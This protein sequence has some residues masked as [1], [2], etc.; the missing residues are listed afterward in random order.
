MH[1]KNLNG[2]EICGDFPFIINSARKICRVRDSRFVRSSVV[3]FNAALSTSNS[4]SLFL[5]STD[6]GVNGVVVVEPGVNAAGVLLDDEDP[7]DLDD[8]ENGGGG[9]VGDIT[10][11]RG[12]EIVGAD[13]VATDEPGIRISR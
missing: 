5:V 6:G 9:C 7:V 8:G 2:T 13:V 4:T 3:N 12:T 10:A 11:V 1:E